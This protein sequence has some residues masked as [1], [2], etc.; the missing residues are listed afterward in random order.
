[1]TDVTAAAPSLCTFRCLETGHTFDLLVPADASVVLTQ[2][3][4]CPEHHVAA[5]RE[6]DGRDHRR[7]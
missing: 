3:A 6:R 2:A 1:M 7:V 5:V 4:T